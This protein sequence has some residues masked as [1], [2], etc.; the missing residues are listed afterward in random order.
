MDQLGILKS[1]ISNHIQ[2]IKSSPPPS[3]KKSAVGDIE[4]D[5]EMIESLFARDRNK[6]NLIPLEYYFIFNLQF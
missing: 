4:A 6:Y 1:N 2:T 5:P 3:V